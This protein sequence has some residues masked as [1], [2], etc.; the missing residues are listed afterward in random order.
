MTFEEFI[1]TKVRNFWIEEPGGLA[2]YVRKSILPGRG[3]YELANMSAEHPG[4]GALT[5]FLDK[6]EKHYSFLVENVFNPRL[7]KFLERRGY[8]Q[9]QNTSSFD[10]SV[11]Y[12]KEKA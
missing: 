8:K 2:I 6:Y 4:N 11:S 3:D 9:V 1:N 10:E 12:I 7:A 5:K